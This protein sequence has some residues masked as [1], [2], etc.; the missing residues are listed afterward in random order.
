MRGKF[1][2]ALLLLLPLTLAA[3]PRSCQNITMDHVEFLRTLPPET[4]ANLT[5]RSDAKGL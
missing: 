1:I 3:D 4:K 5:K 2:P